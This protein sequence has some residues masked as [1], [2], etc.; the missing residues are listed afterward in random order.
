MVIETLWRY[1][2]AVSCQLLF[3]DSIRPLVVAVTEEAALYLELSDQE[4]CPAPPF[5]LLWV[6]DEVPAQA[7]IAELKM[8]ANTE[9]TIIGAGFALI[10]LLGNFTIFRFLASININKKT[11]YPVLIFF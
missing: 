7:K 2:Q 3:T 11:W 1:F 4:S 10:V 5:Q 6:H 8:A 9:K